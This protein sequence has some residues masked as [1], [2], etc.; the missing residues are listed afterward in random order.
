MKQ[1]WN[2]SKR[3]FNACNAGSSLYPGQGKISTEPLSLSKNND[4]ELESLSWP[5]FFLEKGTIWCVLL[6]NKNI[7]EINFILESKCKTKKKGL[8]LKL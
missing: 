6:I 5:S 1:A 3:H 8:N 4:S 2:S 7:S